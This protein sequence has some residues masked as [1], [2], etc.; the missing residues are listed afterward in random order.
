LIEN[1]AVAGFHQQSTVNN[2]E[3]A[4]VYGVDKNGRHAR[5]VPSSLGPETRLWP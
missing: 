5:A 1:L 2:P 3:S 4:I